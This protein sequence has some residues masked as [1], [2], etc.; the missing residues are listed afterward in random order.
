L[1]GQQSRLWH[2]LSGDREYFLLVRSNA[3]DGRGKRRVAQP[4]PGGKNCDKS[5]SGGRSTGQRY[6]ALLLHQIGQIGV[7]R[8]LAGQGSEDRHR[9]STLVAFD[10]NQIGA[11]GQLIDF[12]TE[13]LRL[14]CGASISRD[15]A[16]N[17]GQRGG[18]PDKGDNRG[19]NRKNNATS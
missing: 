15:R 9:S 17:A 7:A 6:P 18:L 8:Q 1:A 11:V 19:R 13:F 5:R 3:R 4:L 2:N 10:L 12:L 16:L 14:R